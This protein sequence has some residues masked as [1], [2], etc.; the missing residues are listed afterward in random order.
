MR[1][2][3]AVPGADGIHRLDLGPENIVPK[4]LD[5]KLGRLVS[6]AVA[7]AAA[8]SGVAGVPYPAHYPQ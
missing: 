8:E 7:G 3:P 4:L 2:R 6:S 5:G 1:R